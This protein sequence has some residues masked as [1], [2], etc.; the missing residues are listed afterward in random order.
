[1]AQPA[2]TTDIDEL[3]K[4]IKKLKSRS[5]QFK[6]DLHDLSEELPLGYE[7]IMEVASKT[8]ET[9]RELDDLQ[10]QLKALES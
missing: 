3:K 8:Y 5:I 4:R 10:K 1:M 6:M 9:Y 7:K 2:M